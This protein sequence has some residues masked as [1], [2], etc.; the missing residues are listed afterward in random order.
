ML[1][2]S[3]EEFFRAC[4]RSACLQVAA[5]ILFALERFEQ[6]LEVSGAEALRAFPLDDLVK[7]RR[8]ILHRLR[9]DLEQISFL[10]T[11]DEDSQI[12]YWRPIFVD[13]ATTLGHGV[14]IGAGNA[15]ELD[16]VVSQFRDC[17]DDVV[18]RDRDVLAPRSLIEL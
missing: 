9:E 4:D 5:K 2:A 14:V 1:C 11:I 10:V 16:S 15:E 12:A 3:C 18:G 13:L 7:Q 6:R 17:L 8:A